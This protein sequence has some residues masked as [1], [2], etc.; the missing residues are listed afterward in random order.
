MVRYSKVSG[1]ILLLYT[2]YRGEGVPGD[3]ARLLFI[4]KEKIMKKRIPRKWK[5]EI[6]KNNPWIKKFDKQY[7][8]VCQKVINHSV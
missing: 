7:Q 5:K 2:Y 4:F 6:K 1:D 3:W 8:L